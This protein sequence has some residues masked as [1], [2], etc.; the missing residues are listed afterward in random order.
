VSDRRT[1]PLRRCDFC[2]HEGP[3]YTAAFGIGDPPELPSWCGQCDPKT[4]P[5]KRPLPTPQGEEGEGK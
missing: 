3:D 1:V 2:G 5:W 4:A